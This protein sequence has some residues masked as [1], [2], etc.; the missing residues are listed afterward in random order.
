[1]L[2]QLL[3]MTTSHKFPFLRLGVCRHNKR[4]DCGSNEAAGVRCDNGTQKVIPPRCLGSGKL[5]L[6]GGANETEGN[7]YFEGKPIC[8]DE[9]TFAEAQGW[10]L[11]SCSQSQELCQ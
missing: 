9:W 11:L 1:M 5:C 6:L 2:T 10:K 8:D 7:V 4:D 3:T